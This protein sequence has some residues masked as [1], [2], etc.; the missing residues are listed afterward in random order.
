MYDEWRDNIKGMNK[1]PK[2]D[3]LRKN[4]AGNRGQKEK[5]ESNKCGSKWINV[6]RVER[7]NGW[8]DACRRGK[9]KDETG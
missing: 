5:A 3:T 2:N 1:D 8:G 6:E 9:K 7:K 4:W